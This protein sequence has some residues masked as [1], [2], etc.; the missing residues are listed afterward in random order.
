MRD[1]R[2]R[3]SSCVVHSSYSARSAGIG[4]RIGSRDGRRAI[5]GTSRSN[6][7][8]TTAAASSVERLRLAHFGWSCG[9]CA[10]TMPKIH[11]TRRN[12]SMERFPSP[13]GRQ[14]AGRA[15]NGHGVGASRSA[16]WLLT[17][18]SRASAM[19]VTWSR[20]VKD[21]PHSQISRAG[22]RQHSGLPHWH[23]SRS[24]R[25]C[26]GQAVPRPIDHVARARWFSPMHAGQ[27]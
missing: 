21:K 26:F 7:R 12:V 3:R 19:T 4:R 24:R 25:P 14:L 11:S 8:H 1:E 13:I 17:A 20:V 23:R 27:I 2:H 10:S 18:S 15:A 16:I 9:C 22:R 5:S 6:A